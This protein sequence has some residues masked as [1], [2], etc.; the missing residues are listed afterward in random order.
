[1]AD[2]SSSDSRSVR[3]PGTL[4]SSRKN[5]NKDSSTNNVTEDE[6]NDSAIEQLTRYVERKLAI[7]KKPGDWL[8][9]HPWNSDNKPDPNLKM[10]DTVAMSSTYPLSPEWERDTN[11]NTET[12]ESQKNVDL[13]KIFSNLRREMQDL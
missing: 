6:P 11:T 13:D 2:G 10:K 1:M 4:F 5:T 9:D 8:Q 3:R 12:T 7:S